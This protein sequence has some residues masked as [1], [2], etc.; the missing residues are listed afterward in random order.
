MCDAIVVSLSRSRCFEKDITFSCGFFSCSFSLLLPC[1][2]SRV[3]LSPLLCHPTHTRRPR[4]STTAAGGRFE[5]LSIRRPVFLIMHTLSLF[6]FSPLRTLR[7]N[8]TAAAINPRPGL[9][10][11]ESLVNRLPLPTSS[12]ALL[13]QSKQKT[14]KAGKI[15]SHHAFSQP[16]TRIR[17]STTGQQWEKGGRTIGFPLSPGLWLSPKQKNAKNNVLH[18]MN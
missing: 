3:L 6:S 5:T 14:K 10:H 16:R 2:P 8:L 1:C 7:Q 9:G 13:F 12:L 18:E 15:L 4:Q 17:Q 11:D